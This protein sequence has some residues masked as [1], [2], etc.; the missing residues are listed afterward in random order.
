M[1]LCTVLSNLCRNRE[2]YVFWD[3]FHPSEKANR[4]IVRHILTGTTKYM[5][6]MNL[7]SALAL[8][9]THDEVRTSVWAILCSGSSI[10]FVYTILFN[11]QDVCVRVHEHEITQVALNVTC[12]FVCSFN[13]KTRFWPALPNTGFFRLY[14]NINY[15]IEKYNF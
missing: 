4:I 11:S 12:F 3:A 15:Y 14:Y 2:L 5:N 1:G 13:W 10:L 8:W 6:P 7:S 9:A